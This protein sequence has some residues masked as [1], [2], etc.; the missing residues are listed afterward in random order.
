[1]FLHPGNPGKRVLALVLILVSDSL[2]T[3]GGVAD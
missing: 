2:E 1:M 3:E